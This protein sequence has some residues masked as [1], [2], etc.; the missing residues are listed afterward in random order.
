MATHSS[1]LAWR[2]PW[3][4]EPGGPWGLRVSH[5]S[6]D[7]ACRDSRLHLG[8]LCHPAFLS[9]LQ[10]LILPRTQAFTNTSL[11]AQYFR[12]FSR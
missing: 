12:F 11:L 8:L 9:C 4:K 2:I 6:S 10:P 7:L 5:N 3:T 1:I